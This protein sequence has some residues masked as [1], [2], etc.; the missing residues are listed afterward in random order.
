MGGSQFNAPSQGRRR[1]RRRR[2]RQVDTIMEVALLLLLLLLLV[3]HTIPPAPSALVASATAI[4]I[5]RVGPDVLHTARLL[6]LAPAVVA[7]LLLRTI[8]YESPL[9]ASPGNN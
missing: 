8:M 5:C 9:Q 4:A 3:P 1:R 6:L 2:R 7:L